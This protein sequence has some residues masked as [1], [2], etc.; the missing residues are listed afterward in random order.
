MISLSSICGIITLFVIISKAM[1]K[2]RKTAM[3]LTE[4]GSML[5]LIFDRFA[6]IY[7]GDVSSLGWWMVRISNFGVFAVAPI[8]IF[9]FNLYLSDLLTEESGIIKLPR[10][11]KIVNILALIGEILIILNIFT[12]IY[13]TFDSTNHYQRSSGFIIGF[14]IPLITLIIM[15]SVIIQYGSGIRPKMRI[16]LLLF[17]TLPV[18]AAIVQVFAYGLSLINITMV[19]TDIVMYVFVVLDMDAAKEAKEE[20]ESE[21]RAKTA[22]LANMSHEIRTPINAVLGMNEMILRECEDEEILEYS[23][24]IRTAGNTLLSLI[25]D[26]LDFSKI[27]AGKME[28]VPVNYDI[29]SV[30]NDLV[31]MI[32]TRAEEKGLELKLDMDE[33]LPKILNGDETEQCIAGCTDI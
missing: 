22:F 17:T 11:M 24:N 25:N 23:S 27:G 21:N 10:R 26:I 7:R 12:G 8:I 20:A 32:S 28:I 2:T 19:G 16:P 6:Y 29:S 31:N 4:G 1:P 5:L 30:I 15:L 13:Y 33:T 18:I 9:G 14:A 3:I